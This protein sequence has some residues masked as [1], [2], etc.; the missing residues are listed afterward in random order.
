[1]IGRN[2]GPECRGFTGLHAMLARIYTLTGVFGKESA[3]CYYLKIKLKD[4]SQ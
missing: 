3:V 2:L 4:V 1:V